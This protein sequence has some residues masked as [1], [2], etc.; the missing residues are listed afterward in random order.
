MDVTRQT[1]E[2]WL[3]GG[4]PA[5]RLTKI[6]AIAEIS[7]ILRHWL[8][9]G[10]PAVVARRPAKAYDGRTM[11]EVLADDDHEWLLEDVRESFNFASVA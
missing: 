8:R 10:M 2:E 4:L 7:D 6:G 1:V 9:E 5:E 3:S 11:L